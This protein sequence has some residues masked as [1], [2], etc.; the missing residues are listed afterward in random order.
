M[1]LSS[2][3][4]S[5]SR[6]PLHQDRAG[7]ASTSPPTGPIEAELPLARHILVTL[8]AI[9]ADVTSLRQLFADDPQLHEPPDRILGRV[10]G[11]STQVVSWC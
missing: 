3:I 2:S 1:S 7:Y 4:R 8:A 5:G 10:G 11:G 6:P 9:A